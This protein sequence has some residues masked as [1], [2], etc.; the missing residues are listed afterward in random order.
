MRVPLA[1]PARVTFFHAKRSRLFS[2][3]I[4]LGAGSLNVISLIILQMS[5]MGLRSRKFAGQ[6][7]F[8]IKFANSFD[9]M[10]RLPLKRE[11]VFH[12]EG[13]SSLSLS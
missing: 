12:P 13:M 5:S 1:C 7:F 9:T 6:P 3:F 8:A 2:S 10:S 11:P 4:V